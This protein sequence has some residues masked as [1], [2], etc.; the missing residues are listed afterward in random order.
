MLQALPRDLSKLQ[1]VLGQIPTIV[2][3]PAA[4]NHHDRTA[5]SHSP[6]GQHT[7]NQQS[8]G[9]SNVLPCRN[10]DKTFPVSLHRTDLQFEAQQC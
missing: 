2:L 5:P 3:H 4:E 8:T 9:S 7:P 6:T 10:D 1:Q